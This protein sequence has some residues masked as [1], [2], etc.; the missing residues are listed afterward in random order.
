MATIVIPD[1]LKRR[2]DTQVEAAGYAD[3]TTFLSD[4][5]EDAVADR[6]SVLTALEEGETSG[7]STLSPDDILEDL[8]RKRLAA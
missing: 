5:I 7:L 4:L 1:A 2:I 3:T 8:L 6:Q